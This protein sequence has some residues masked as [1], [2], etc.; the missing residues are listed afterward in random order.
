[1]QWRDEGRQQRPG[2]ARIGTRRIVRHGWARRGLAGFGRSGWT[3]RGGTWQVLASR[4]RPVGMWRGMTRC[5]KERLVGDGEQRTGT[6]KA[7]PGKSDWARPDWRR[8]VSSDGAGQ[9]QVR[10]DTARLG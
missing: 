1:M 7:W 9:V 6:D 2:A 8:L 5:G 3:W 10:L 4:G